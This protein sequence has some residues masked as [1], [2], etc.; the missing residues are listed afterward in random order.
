MSHTARRKAPYSEYS[1]GTRMSNVEAKT[2]NIEVKTRRTPTKIP[3]I[4][5]KIVN[6]TGRSKDSKFLKEVLYVGRSVNKGGWDL[7]KTKWSNPFPITGTCTREESIRRFKNYIIQ[8][9]EL[10]MDLHS[11]KDKVLGCWCINGN[12]CVEDA[13]C[14]AQIL[15]ALAD[16]VDEGDILETRLRK[17]GI[18]MKIPPPQTPLLKSAHTVRR[19]R[20]DSDVPDFVKKALF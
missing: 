3:R 11:L 2:P 1:F 4:E 7:P 15:G 6:I 19:K 20:E 12:A 14:H 16:L 18:L 17:C 9:E 10:V 8:K 13:K 5:L